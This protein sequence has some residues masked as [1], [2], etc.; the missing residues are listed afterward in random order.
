MQAAHP[1]SQWG[2][3]LTLALMPVSLGPSNSHCLGTQGADAH[4]TGTAEECTP[5]RAKVWHIL[6][7]PPLPGRPGQV[8]IGLGG[9]HSLDWFRRDWRLAHQGS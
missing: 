9:A 2:R 7:P 8:T 4:P 3:S 1:R 5:R 6:L